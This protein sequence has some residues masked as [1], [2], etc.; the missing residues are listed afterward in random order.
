M[1][2][3]P[4]NIFIL[5]LT[6]VSTLSL[7]KAQSLIFD[8]G[9][10]FNSVGTGAGGANES[11]L[12]TT[13]FAMGTIGF[14]H[15]A[16]GFNRVADDFTVA[17]CK[18]RIDSVVFFGYQTGSTTT[19]TFTA[20]NFRIWDSIPDAVGSNVIYGDTTTNALIRTTWSGTYRIT[21]TT[22]GSTQRPIMRNVCIVNSLM[23][24]SGTYWIDWQSSGSLASG[25][26]APA[27]TPVGL[28]ITGNARQRTGQI[29]NN[30][31][32]GGTG[33]PPQGFPFLIYGTVFNINADAGV[34]QSACL[35]QSVI[36]GG[37]PSG[38][39]DFGVN[40]YSWTPI[41]DISN[42]STSNPSL[43]LS[44]TANYILTVSDTAGCMDMD[45]ITV[46]PFP[47]PQAVIS[48]IGG[49]S[50]CPGD[51]ITLNAFSALG[52]QYLWS[53]ADN[54]SITTVYANTNY[55]LDVTDSLGCSNADTISISWYPLPIA[56]ISPSGTI[57]I[58]SGTDI[59]LTAMSGFGYNYL[60]ST[61]ETTENILVSTAGV[62]V[63]DIVDSVGCTAS[64][65][66]T[67]I[68]D[69]AP[70]VGVTQVGP[71]L[72]ADQGG[73][74]YQWIDCNNGNSI[75]SGA[76]SQNFTATAN[77]SYAVIVDLGGCIDTSSCNI[78]FDLGVNGLSDNDM[79]VFP[80]PADEMFFIELTTPIG[81]DYII[82]IYNAVGQEIQIQKLTPSS[83]QMIEINCSAWN[84]GVYLV[85]G[86]EQLTG[87]EFIQ[88]IVVR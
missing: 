36:L 41:A 61:T 9:P 23:I 20:V 22:T 4:K 79:L 66:V 40:S 25:P 75:I 77:G 35:G 83:T 7:S 84:P 63:L 32:D 5:V 48:T 15:Q 88:R 64:D 62:I 82:H 47:L 70:S 78:V 80:N 73:A 65:S 38:S 50:I 30:A 24:N 16:T 28:S 56:S 44:D 55:I 14:G 17:D 19:S 60:W 18:W 31:L 8:N 3:I 74:S 54:D 52:Y 57:S 58:C 69:P 37:I 39:G 10:I 67:I 43:T 49:T 76:I 72:T 59:T 34:D 68:V 2:T 45:T 46:T 51:S 81:N 87:K 27:R 53:N 29:W 33:N 71:S 13:T 86:S 26:W 1:K 12:Y 42:P 21:E 6:F 11:V 85:K